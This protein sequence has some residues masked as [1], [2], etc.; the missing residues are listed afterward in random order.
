MDS[1]LYLYPNLNLNPEFIDFIGTNDKIVKYLDIP[2]QH[3]S[4]PILKSMKRGHDSK[5]IT[6]LIQNL[7]SKIQNLFL[8]TSVIVGFPGET[9]DDFNKLYNFIK[10]HEF[11]HLGVFEYSDEKMAAS[12]NLKN[13]LDPKIINQRYHKLMSLQQE[14]IS[15]KNMELIGMQFQ[16]VVEGFDN[17]QFFGRISGQAFEID[18]IT[19][20]ENNNLAIGDFIDIKITSANIYDFYAKKINLARVKL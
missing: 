12:Y 1:P 14:I 6:E 9:D 8:R 11:D 2:F 5:F 18:G 7:K 17:N 13:K 20:F 16:A 15:K 4:D 3:I 19:Y 10:E